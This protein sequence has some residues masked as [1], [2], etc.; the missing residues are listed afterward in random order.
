MPEAERPATALIVAPWP[1][2]DARQLDDEAEE[3]FGLIQEVITAIRD[4]RKQAEV[5]PAKR[6]QV[7]L[8]AGGRATL[9]KREAAIIEQLARTE[10]PRIERK[11]AAKPEQAMAQV[12]GGVEIYLPLAGMLDLDKE[13]ERLRTQMEAVQGQIERSRK[14]LDNPNFVSRARPDVVQKE[15]DALAAAEDTLA[16]L[17][18]RA[19]EL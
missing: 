19:H 3:S 2:L 17:R 18:A 6:V 8:V 11:L 7:I 10:P 14:M 5:E 15:R 4:T 12:A 16:K 9:L 13:R 1:T